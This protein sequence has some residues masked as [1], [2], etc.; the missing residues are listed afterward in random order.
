MKTYYQNPQ[1]ARVLEAFRTLI[2]GSAFSGSNDTNWTYVGFFWACMRQNAASMPEWCETIGPLEEP[3]KTWWWTAVWMSQTDGGNM[4]LR[5]RINLPEGHPDRLAYDWLKQAPRDILKSGFRGDGK[6]HISMLW[7]AFYATGNEAMIYK[8][9]EGFIPSPPKPP[10]TEVEK[11]LAEHR[12]ASNRRL[13]E[14]TRQSLAQNLVEHPKALKICKDSID[15]LKD[16][17]K[18]EIATLVADAEAAIAKA[19]AESQAPAAPPSSA[20]ASTPEA[21]KEEFKPQPPA[22][23]EPKPDPKPEPSPSPNPR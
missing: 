13:I 3:A 1:P 6:N 19:A 12:V 14:G 18:T 17:V 2:R 21:P 11:A 23:T 10:T 22:A 8:L 16:P 15:N 7:H 9:Y 20:S 4:V 5:D